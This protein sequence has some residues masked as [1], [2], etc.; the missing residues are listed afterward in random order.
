MDTNA[1]PSVLGGEVVHVPSSC[2]A[3]M[4]INFSTGFCFKDTSRLA[5]SLSSRFLGYPC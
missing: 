2:S 4:V 5:T 3:K 1:V